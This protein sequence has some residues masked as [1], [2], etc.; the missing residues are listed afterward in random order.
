MGGDSINSEGESSRSSSSQDLR[1]N[2][3]PGKLHFPAEEYLE[4]EIEEQEIT[5]LDGDNGPWLTELSGMHVTEGKPT[6]G[7]QALLESEPKESRRVASSE[8]RAKSQL[9]KE[10]GLPWVEEGKYSP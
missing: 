2:N 8:V 4:T 10:A 5:K 7:T 6:K 1:K 9:L 3:D